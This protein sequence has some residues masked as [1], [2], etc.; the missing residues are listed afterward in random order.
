[1]NLELLASIQACLDQ[2][3]DVLLS[4][5]SGSARTF[6][7]Q[8]LY[9]HSPGRLLYIA[10]SEEQ[11]YD[12]AHELQELLGRD[13]ISLFMERDFVFR[14]ESTSRTAVERIAT[15]QDLLVHPR[16]KSIIITTLGA[17]LFR[18]IPPARMQ[19]ATRRLSLGQETPV[20]ELLRALVEAGYERVDTIT[21]PGQLALRGG[22]L[23]IF[24]AGEPEPYRAE[25]F[26]DSLDSLRRFDLNT[27]R[28]G[29]L[30]PRC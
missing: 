9:R 29:R 21:R 3:K 1:M 27:Q 7:L 5:L 8:E 24:P 13:K 6:M 12:L 22:I 18:I 26:G 2:H 15:L 10:A 4:G 19:Q 14:S 17:L 30:R 11:A 28:S 20:Y 16:R 23:D 25:F